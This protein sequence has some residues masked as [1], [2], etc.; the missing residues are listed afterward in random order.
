MEESKKYDLE[1]DKSENNER[2]QKEIPNLLKVIDSQEKGDDD[3]PVDTD[4]DM[5]TN[6]EKS[7]EIYQIEEIKE[8]YL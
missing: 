2:D 5:E 7:E 1:S 8:D 6:D 4:I 3:V